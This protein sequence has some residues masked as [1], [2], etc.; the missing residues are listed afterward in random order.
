[1][2]YRERMSAWRPPGWHSVTPRLV[3]ADPAEMVRFLQNAFDASCDF[4][5]GAPAIAR[6]GDSIVMVSA[7]GPRQ[8]T[9]AL[10][11]LYVEDA[12]ATY[13]RAIASGATSL[14]EPADMPYGDRRAII[15]DPCGN[16]WQVATYLR[17]QPPSMQAERR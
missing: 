16:L 12:D 8:A 13:R 2:S 1:M 14:E 6:I 7:A 9:S 11:Y 15:R 3:V 17:P 4:A 10:L 5:E